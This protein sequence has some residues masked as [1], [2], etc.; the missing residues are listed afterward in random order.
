VHPRHRTPQVAIL[1]YSVLLL[2]LGVSG[3]FEGLAFITN[4]SALALYLG[5]AV[6]AWQLRSGAGTTFRAR[7]RLG[8]VVPWLACAVIAWLL[9]GA[10]R[11]EW[12]ALGT[13]L[14]IATFIYAV[15][16]SRVR[17]TGG[18][19]PTNDQFRESAPAAVIS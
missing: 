11:A 14:A 17:G 16:R 13:C 15:A 1:A 12:L 8:G 7:L 19:Q 2:M 3:T 6:A 9:T 4:L 10:S 18:G 5:C